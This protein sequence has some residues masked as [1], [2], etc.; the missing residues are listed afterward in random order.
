MPKLPQ[1]SGLQLVKLLQFLGYE[2]IRQK[3]SHLRLKK[4]TIL[5]EHAITVPAHKVIAKGTL[6]DIIGKVSLWNNISQEE[7]IKRL[8]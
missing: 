4:V 2:I 1:V 5:G 8:K 7:F 3:G 6:A